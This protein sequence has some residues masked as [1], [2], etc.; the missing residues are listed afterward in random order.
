MNS[1]PDVSLKAIPP[2]PY[3]RLVASASR[4]PNRL[5]QPEKVLTVSCHPDFFQIEPFDEK[6]ERLSCCGTTS[7]AKDRGSFYRLGPNIPKILAGREDACRCFFDPTRFSTVAVDTIRADG[8]G[9]V[10][11][12]NSH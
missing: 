9:K 6:V 11:M 5:A 2:Y 10:S 4:R 3:R 1:T 8:H 7:W 12:A